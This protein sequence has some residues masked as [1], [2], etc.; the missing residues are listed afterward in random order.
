MNFTYNDFW[1]LGVWLR[2]DC[3]NILQFP[4]EKT[5]L[6]KL[7][8]SDFIFTSYF[9]VCLSSYFLTKLNDLINSN[10][11]ISFSYINI[12]TSDF[13][14]FEIFLKENNIDIIYDDIW[15]APIIQISKNY[16]FQEFFLSRKRRLQITMKK[17][18]KIVK[19]NNLSFDIKF[20][21]SSNI[22]LL[23][24]DML[25]IDNNCWKKFEKSD[26]KSLER[27][28]LQYLTFA[29]MKSDSVS[30]SICYCN[31]TPVAFSFMF[32]CEESD[33]WY[34]VKWGTSD[35]GRLYY[36]GIYLL[37]NHIEFLF[38]KFK[39]DNK[40]LNIDLW[41]RRSEIYNQISTG[42]RTRANFTLKRR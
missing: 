38:N 5:S 18:K 3:N 27:E 4:K 36:S 9:D 12:D 14:E 21:D 35:L 30:L 26:M 17:I 22:F 33:N 19:N 42:T 8:D 28:D 39:S 31:E 32:Y 40:N 10:K 1:S 34:A 6:I 16:S 11:K 7:N 37:I 15:E 29:L 41:G 20:S 23:W 25:Y 13:T 2:Y 24:K